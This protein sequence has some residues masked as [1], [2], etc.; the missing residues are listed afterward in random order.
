MTHAQT[1]AAIRLS[2]QLAPVKSDRADEAR[3]LKGAKS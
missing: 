1:V 3:V 2:L